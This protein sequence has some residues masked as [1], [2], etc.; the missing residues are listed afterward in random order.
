MRRESGHL[1]DQVD[2]WIGGDCSNPVV[3]Q[4]QVGLIQVCAVAGGRRAGFMAKTKKKTCSGNSRARSCRRFLVARA[5]R[6]QHNLAGTNK[7]AA[8]QLVVLVLR[9]Y[10]DAGFA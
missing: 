3:M 8:S 10:L 7:L 2:E 6:G 4:A 9:H 1:L 5:D